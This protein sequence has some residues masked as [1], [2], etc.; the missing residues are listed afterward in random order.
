V[1]GVDPD[2]HLIRWDA[3]GKKIFLARAEGPTSLSIYRLD[4]A[5]GQRELWKKLAPADST[6]LTRGDTDSVLLTPDAKVYSYTYMRDLSYLF[7][8]EGLK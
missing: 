5:S 4:P 6:G 8:V 3:E 7:M 2:D 1:P